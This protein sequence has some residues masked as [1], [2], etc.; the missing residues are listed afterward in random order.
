MNLGTTE[1]PPL[2]STSGRTTC[3]HCDL[4]QRTTGRTTCGPCDLFHLTT[5]GPCG[6]PNKTEVAAVA[7]MENG[8]PASPGVLSN[9]RR[10][11]RPCFSGSRSCPLGALHFFFKT[12]RRLRWGGWEK[13][14][15]DDR[16]TRGVQGRKGGRR[17]TDTWRLPRPPHDVLRTRARPARTGRTRTHV[18]APKHKPL[19]HQSYQIIT[20]E[21]I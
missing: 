8:R 20:H 19:Q 18:H 5:C 1:Q 13:P 21:L 4:F 14:N 12:Y 17:A 10:D 15:D 7:T 6:L 3:G 2:L 9:P 11:R 16:T